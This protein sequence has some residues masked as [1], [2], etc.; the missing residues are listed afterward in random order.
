MGDW[1][2]GHLFLV[3]L[4]SWDVL[5]VPFWPKF[6]PKKKTGQNQRAWCRLL[7][8]QVVVLFPVCGK[9]GRI[10]L[11]PTLQTIYHGRIERLFYMKTLFLKPRFPV[12]FSDNDPNAS[13]WAKHRSIPSGTIGIPLPRLCISH[14]LQLQLGTGQILQ[15]TCIPWEATS[16]S[17]VFG[18]WVL[19]W[20]ELVWP[21]GTIGAPNY[22]YTMIHPSTGNMIFL[23][24]NDLPWHFPQ[25]H[26]GSCVCQTQHL[27]VL[28]ARLFMLFAHSDWKRQSGPW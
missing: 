6:A 22:G 5:A 20:F 24:S 21:R 27:A 15:A 23:P 18:F 1:W 13:A 17:S 12:D 10:F 26:L 28:S 16:E 19:G 4:L 11:V 2:T 8:L 14:M 3:R 9:K 7:I 25:S